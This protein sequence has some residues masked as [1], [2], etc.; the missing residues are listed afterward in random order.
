MGHIVIMVLLFSVAV[1]CFYFSVRGIKEA[2]KNKDIAG[3]IIS[4]A[5]AVILEAFWILKFIVELYTFQ[6][7]N[8]PYWL[9]SLPL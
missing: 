2:R 8:L 6:E 9:A 3:V 1:L 4:V 7:W 5:V